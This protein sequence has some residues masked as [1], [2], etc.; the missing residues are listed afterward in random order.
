MHL[1]DP[2]G[3]DAHFRLLLRRGWML[4]E[5]FFSAGTAAVRFEA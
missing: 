1:F 2:A 3:D 4:Y 5:Y